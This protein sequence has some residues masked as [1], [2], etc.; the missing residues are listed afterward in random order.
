M[1][2]VAKIFH[3]T[4]RRN[5]KPT[6]LKD[7]DFEVMFCVFVMSVGMCVKFGHHCWGNFIVCQ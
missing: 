3:H 7:A 6:N 4:W 1:H 5:G 2:L